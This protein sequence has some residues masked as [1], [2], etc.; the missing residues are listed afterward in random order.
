MNFLQLSYAPWVVIGMLVFIFLV[1]LTERKFFNWIR[2]HWLFQRRFSHRL[3][4]VLLLLGFA[5]LSVILL[6]PRESET[7]IKG[8]I[9]KD[10][11]IIL[12]DTSTSMLTEDVRPNRLDRA[13]LV[14][15]HFIRKAVGH[16][17]AIIVFA[18]ITKKLV[19]F[20]TD[21]DLL[22]A[23]MDS[24]KQ[25]KNM[26]AGSAIGLAIEEAVQHF[27]SKDDSVK[28]NLLV[29]TD[30]EDNADSANFKVPEG[31]SVAFVG[32]GTQEGGPIPMKDN[33]GMFYGHKRSQG[34]T[35]TSKLNQD[36]FSTALKSIPHA[37]YFPV[38]SFD[39]PT[40]EIL[41]FFEQRKAQE[42]EGDN[43]IRPVALERW[44]YPAV[45]A[46]L[47]GYLLRFWRPLV[48]VALIVQTLSFS[49]AQEKELPPE[50]IQRIDQLKKGQ[51]DREERINLAD[52]LVQYKMHDMAQ[53]LYEENMTTEDM[54]E[55]QQSYFNWATSE[56]E[57][58]KFEGALDKY[59][60]LEA[61]AKSKNDNEL[62]KSIK[63]NIKRVMVPPPEKQKQDKKEEQDKQNQ[64]NKDQQN[65]D[66]S[67]E[68]K[69]QQGSGNSQ[70]QEKNKNDSSDGKDDK[71][72]PFDMKKDE[73]S[74]QKKDESQDKEEKKKEQGMKPQ[75]L[76]GQ[77]EE[78][79]KIKVSPL[80]EQLKQDDRKLQ[81][82]LLDTSTQKRTDRKKK[83]W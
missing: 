53:A 78:K 67:G 76:E 45:V 34:Q 52:Q 66:E 29:I 14:G 18:D 35:V 44:L 6:D 20:T 46:L 60:D 80:L 58:G 40:M 73:Q 32:V 10:R 61:Q 79:K 56:L 39:L 37:K 69:D 41:S 25:L 49:H 55:R 16:E 71:K 19:P 48:M 70:Q 5:L 26:N 4:S 68:G 83:D 1:I 75:E 64:E 15:K 22:D 2:E 11:T 59:S 8:K 50:I 47:L 3:S 57:T 82:K 65:Q 43:V 36:F 81:L 51:L 31:I 24:I 7:R 77:G 54:T 28:G 23:R 21:I 72:N 9:R 38:Q 17:V 42:A 13:V 62:L 33:M 63:E 74:D 27:D 12:V 30:G